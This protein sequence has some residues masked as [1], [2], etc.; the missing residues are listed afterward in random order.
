MPPCPRQTATLSRS[1]RDRVARPHRKGQKPM[2]QPLR[3]PKHEKFARAIAADGK[4][5]AQ[6][7]V[8]AGFQRDRANHWKLL[9]NPRVKERVA[10]LMAARVAGIPVGDMLIELE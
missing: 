2:S 8:D 5:P 7:Y 4:D 3:N 1:N 9:R 10:E 6:A